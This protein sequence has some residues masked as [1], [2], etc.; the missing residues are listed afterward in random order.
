MLV[1]AAVEEDGLLGRPVAPVRR[2]VVQGGV[3][4]P[5]GLGAGQDVE[6]VGSASGQGRGG[7]GGGVEERN[8]EAGGARG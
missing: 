7:G 8:G 2:R 5:G 6:R 1:V 3:A 4:R